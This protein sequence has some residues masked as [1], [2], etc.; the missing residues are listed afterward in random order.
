MLSLIDVV[1]VDRGVPSRL[2]IS[3]LSLR[4]KP[5]LVEGALGDGAAAGAGFDAGDVCFFLCFLTTV[6]Q[7]GAFGT[8]GV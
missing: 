6:A 7:V 3:L 2:M 4:V 8:I 5:F 1:V